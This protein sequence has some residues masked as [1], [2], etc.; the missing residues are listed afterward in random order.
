MENKH[1][2]IISKPKRYVSNEP[3]DKYKNI[4]INNEFVIGKDY[5]M[6]IIKDGI[7]KQ[8]FVYIVDTEDIPL[9][10]KYEWRYNNKYACALGGIYLPL[11]NLIMGIPEK[12]YVVD[13]I[14]R[15]AYDNRKSNLR[16][17]TNKE[18]LFNRDTKGYRYDKRRKTYQAYI[19]IGD[20]FINLGVYKTEEEAAAARKAVNEYLFPKIRY[21]EDD[22]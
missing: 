6:L 13:H 20:K 10:S 8:D 14:N 19:H 17:V 18:N 5:S 1:G 21:Y 2:N 3:I 9:I 15:N 12:G 16:I 11:H 22:V 4:F 7:K